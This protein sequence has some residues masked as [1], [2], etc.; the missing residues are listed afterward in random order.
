[1]AKTIIPY[2]EIAS[3]GYGDIYASFASGKYLRV[4][5]GGIRPDN[6]S[7]HYCG[8]SSYRWLDGFF[9][10]IHYDGTLYNSDLYFTDMNCIKCGADFIDGDDLTLKV[11]SVDGVLATVPIHLECSQASKVKRTV[12][13]KKIKTIRELIRGK[14]IERQNTVIEKSLKTIKRVKNKQVLMG[15]K[16]VQKM[17][18]QD[19]F[20]TETG[21]MREVSVPKLKKRLKTRYY[22]DEYGN[23]TSHQDLIEVPDME[24]VSIYDSVPLAELDTQGNWRDDKGNILTDEEALEE[25]ETEVSE[26]V[27][28]EKEIEI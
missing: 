1:M 23:I 18:I 27:Y 17:L 20:D 5:G 13:V 12:R 15:T 21:L 16:K 22:Q 9:N 19:I 3:P 10:D 7:G 2:I 25:V 4:D 11:L 8:N 28:L 26:V 24:E 14:A 6:D